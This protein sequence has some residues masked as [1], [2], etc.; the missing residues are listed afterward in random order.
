MPFTEPQSLS[1]DE[2]YAVTAY[3]LALND[4]IDEDDVID[5]RSLPRIEMPN[6]DNFFWSAEVAPA[7]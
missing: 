6:R 1:N 4:I 7:E 5:A 2:V 3:L